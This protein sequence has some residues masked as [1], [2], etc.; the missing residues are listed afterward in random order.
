[1]IKDEFISLMNSGGPIMWVIF[2]VACITLTLLSWEAFRGFLL[3]KKT[4]L[5]YQRM[6]TAGTFSISPKQVQ[7]SS[8]P[9][10]QLL[11][12]VS[13]P[14]LESKNQIAKE[15]NLHISEIS[16]RV[17]GSLATIATLGSLLPML[18]LLGT[19]TGMI[20]V[21]E[22]I[23]IQGSGKPEEMADGISQALLTTA[24][25]LIIA[26]PVIF[27]HHLLASRINSIMIVTHQSIDLILN[28]DVTLLNRENAH[29]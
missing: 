7:S 9:I 23:A 26:I 29:E 16:K 4:Q 14:K 28:D 10:S 12:E 2:F 21:F 27:F 18:G 8:S 5:D 1:M 24:S 22:V 3:M 25:G 13:Y 17:E 20:N 15:F 19:V 6:R 11:S